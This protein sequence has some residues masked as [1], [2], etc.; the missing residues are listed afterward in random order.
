[1]HAQ[2]DR[3]LWNQLCRDFRHVFDTDDETIGELLVVADRHKPAPQ[4]RDARREITA[5]NDD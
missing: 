5:A 4:R 3:H 2:S 1:M